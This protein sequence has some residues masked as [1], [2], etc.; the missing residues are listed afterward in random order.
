MAL[1]KMSRNTQAAL[2]LGGAILLLHFYNQIFYQPLSRKIRDLKLEKMNLESQIPEG[3]VG[4]S[5]LLDLEEHY[6][7]RF[8]EYGEFERKVRE[9]ESKLPSKKEMSALLEQ[10]T[11]SLEGSKAEFISVE[12]TF[13]KAAEGEPFDSIDI[14]LYFRSDFSELIQCIQ[15]LEKSSTILGIRSVT[16]EP[17]EDETKK[18][19][20]TVQFSTFISDHAHKEDLLTNVEK[21]KGE[22]VEGSGKNQEAASKKIEAPAEPFKP[23]AK[24]YDQRLPGEHKLTMIVWKGKNRVALID[25]K[26]MKEGSRL[27]NRILTEVEEGGVWFSEGGLKYFL[28]LE[29]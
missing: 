23:E 26:V 13:R 1:I 8:E 14:E 17:G 10:L 11:T 2:F 16:L 7:K 15:N 29:A 24:P 12:P 18:P 28:A 20:V 5:E 25:G 27:E 9:L 4:K 22:K 3:E 6:K 19:S 21:K